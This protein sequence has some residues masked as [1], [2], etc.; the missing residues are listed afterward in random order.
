MGKSEKKKQYAFERTAHTAC[1]IKRGESELSHLFL[2]SCISY[3]MHKQDRRDTHVT[4]TA[5]FV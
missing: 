2:F 5:L 1:W 4:H 3:P